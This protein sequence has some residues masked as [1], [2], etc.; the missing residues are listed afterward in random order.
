MCVK[1]AASPE[2][3]IEDFSAGKSLQTHTLTRT[4]SS[5]QAEGGISLCQQAECNQPAEEPWITLSVNLFWKSDK[6]WSA[7]LPTEW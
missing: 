1:I 6:N 4:V 3:E 7:C 2:A 5:R